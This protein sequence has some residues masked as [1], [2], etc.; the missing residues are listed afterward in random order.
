MTQQ[1]KPTPQV[2]VPDTHIVVLLDRSGSMESIA[3]DVIGGYN[4][5]I[6]EQLDNGADAKVTLV[7]FDSANPHEIIHDA[8]PIADVPRLTE[9]EF[10]PRASTPLLDATGRLI[11][12]I[13]ERLALDS[14]PTEQHDSIVFVTI[15]DGEENDS[16]EFTLP[17][18]REMIANCE[19]DGWTFVFLSAGLDAYG[20][21]SGMG[22]QQG[23]TRAF[24][25]T[26]G[27]AELAFAALSENMTN[28]RDK[29]RRMQDT[30]NDDFFDDSKFDRILGDD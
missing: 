28:L 24:S 7:Q 5:F 19:R 26:K 9:K 23:R 30:S 3:S 22:V 2:H 6:R 29:K 1:D 12:K 20:E 27:G 13:R 18:T 16:T 8:L 25:P 15:T 17:Q 4:R 14:R 11:A 10:I 21:A